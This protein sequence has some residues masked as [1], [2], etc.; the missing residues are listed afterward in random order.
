MNKDLDKRKVEISGDAIDVYPPRYDLSGEELNVLE[1]ELV[2]DI[3]QQVSD[4]GV[5]AVWIYPN[6][7]FANILRAHEANHFP[8]VSELPQDIED[9][10]LFFALVDTRG[11]EDRVVHSTTVSGVLGRRMGEV[12]PNN[13]DAP[14]TSGFIVI[15]DLIEMG[16]FTVEEFWEYY[17]SNGIDLGSSISVETNFRVGD[18]VSKFKDM[19]ISDIAY[20]SLFR[21]LKQRSKNLDTKF[22]SSVVF[23][24]IND[25]TINSFARV[26]I[27]CSPLMGRSDLVTS[28]SEAG[29]D[30]KPVTIPNNAKIFDDIDLVVPELTYS[31]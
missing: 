21:L 17:A 18:R 20:L 26:G 8:E 28:E 3:K 13:P 1:Q 16:N 12:D 30:F 22:D 5:V 14:A 27:V 2:H 7:K 15:D 6:H 24:S 19:N 23:A 11:G 25:N 9:R 10:S 29:L 4:E 31:L